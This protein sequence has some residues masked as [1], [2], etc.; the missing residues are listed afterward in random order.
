MVRTV[1]IICLILALCVAVTGCKKKAAGGVT[2]AATKY[3]CPMHPDQVSDTPG[4]CPK[5]GMA[6]MPQP[7]QAKP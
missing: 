5:C 2:G 7:P 3:T 4:P 6:M 1:I